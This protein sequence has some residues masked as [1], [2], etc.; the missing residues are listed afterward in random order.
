[1]VFLTLERIRNYFS[2]RLNGDDDNDVAFYRPD[3]IYLQAALAVSQISSL[4]KA[5]KTS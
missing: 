3:L 1:M 4:C 5:V 2:R